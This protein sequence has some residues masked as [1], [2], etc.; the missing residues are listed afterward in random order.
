MAATALATV[1]PLLP[2]IAAGAA[3]MELARRLPAGL[4]TD[5]ARAGAFRMLVPASLG[6]LE[7]DPATALATIERVAAADAATGWC[8]MIGATAALP[9]A[10]LAPRVARELFRPETIVAG[11][12]APMGRAVASADGYRLSGRWA[13]GSGG[14]NAHWLSG[15]AIVVDADGK[16]VPGA[17]GAPQT[18]MFFFPAAQ[19]SFHDTWHVTGLQ[20]TG[21]NDF[22]VRDLA[23]RHD[24]SVALTTDRPWADG[25]LYRFPLFGL[26]SL[27]IAAVALGNARAAIDDLVML[28]TRKT[29]MGGQRT[30]AERGQVQASVADA[31][32]RLR[33]A[34]ALV[35]AEVAEAWAVAAGGA[36]LDLDTRAR[37]RL[38]ATHATRTAA[39]VARTMYDLGGGTSVFDASPLQR[40]FRDAHVATQHMMIAPPSYELTGR[41]LLGLPT[42]ATL[43]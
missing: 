8:V 25:P 21:S 20:G 22:E 27:G 35:V 12:F 30:L 26:L 6:G 13:W 40:R 28:A 2:A 31:T 9:S 10:Y 15:G 36:S 5:L 1:E 3:A 19:A 39:G 16:P 41:V 23:V 17:D 29:P 43:L 34:R 32:A 4:A 14:A 18:R 38:A 11:V 37:L 24:H 7:C 33:A 42:A